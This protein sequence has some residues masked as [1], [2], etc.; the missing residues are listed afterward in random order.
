M[1]TMQTTVPLRADL[2]PQ[3]STLSQS[4]KLD[5]STSKSSRRL[6]FHIPSSLPIL[7]FTAN[8]WSKAIADVK[9]DYVSRRYGPCVAR[10][11]DIL[12][13]LRDKT[14]VEPIY[15]IYIHF[16]AASSQ[17][18]MARTFYHAS[19]QRRNLFYQ[20]KEHY[21]KASQLITAATNALHS[22]KTFNLGSVC[23]DSPSSARTS[24]MWTPST[25][26]ETSSRSTSISSIDEAHSPTKRQRR[27]PGHQT[28][29]SIEPQSIVRPDS[30]TLGLSPL[31][32]TSF[33][34]LLDAMPS[35]PPHRPSSRACIEPATPSDTGSVTSLHSSHR[36]SVLLADLRS[37]VTRHL[38]FIESELTTARQP[39]PVTTNLGLGDKKQRSMDLRARIER[40]RAGGWQRRRFDASR[41]EELREN[42]MADIIS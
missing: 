23:G 1:A 4:H 32:D 11:N 15:L 41:Y 29:S 12:Q 8:E 28:D 34:D 2:S 14:V 36:L 10:C 3:S 33:Q 26:S 40:L 13:N 17:E 35:P 27:R 25:V 6:P 24:G 21:E 9:K 31:A 38:S 16:Y 18:S 37:Q 7:P 5:I 19:S 30:P 39:L 42:A 22:D 20:A